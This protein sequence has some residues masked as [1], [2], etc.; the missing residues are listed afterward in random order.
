L[1][2]GSGLR[3]FREFFKAESD[4][5]LVKVEL[6]GKM[7][8]VD[9][10]GNGGDPNPWPTRLSGRMEELLNAGVHDKVLDDGDDA[11]TL[12]LRQRDQQMSA[13]VDNNY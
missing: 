6:D 7:V 1:D 12:L 4:D 11:S 5:K 3:V 9:V 10:C 8:E 2:G 13:T